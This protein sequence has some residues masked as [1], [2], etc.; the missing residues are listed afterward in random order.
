M[1]HPRTVRALAAV[2]VLGAGAGVGL[3]LGAWAGLAWWIHRAGGAPAT[4]LLPAVGS[5]AVGAIGGAALGAGLGGLAVGLLTALADRRPD[6]T[7]Q[8]RGS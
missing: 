2:A 1:A 6:R 5:A 4:S 7:G 3:V 8:N